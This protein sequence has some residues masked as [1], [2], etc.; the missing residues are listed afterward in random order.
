MALVFI[1]GAGMAKT[2]EESP[3]GGFMMGALSFA[4]IVWMIIDIT[5]QFN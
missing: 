4:L 5:K 2:I 3:V 1:L